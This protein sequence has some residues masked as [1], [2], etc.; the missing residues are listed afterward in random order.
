M[1]KFSGGEIFIVNNKVWG[2]K[3]VVVNDKSYFFEGSV[4][5]NIFLKKGFSI[6]S[7]IL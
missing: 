5:K 4:G 6:Y 2:F 7:S 1:K 3:F